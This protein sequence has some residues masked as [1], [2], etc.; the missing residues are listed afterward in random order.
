[1][2]TDIQ[3]LRG[4]AVLLV[5]FYHAEFSWFSKGYLGVDVF[6]VVSGY[7]I[8]GLIVRDLDN[9]TFSFKQFYFRRLK[10]LA[11]AAYATFA[12]TSVIA[13]YLLSS[14]ELEDYLK[15]LIGA[16]TFTGNIALW[17]QTGYFQGAA[18]FKPLLH[19]WSLAIEEQFYLVLP[20][21][22]YLLPAARRYKL[23]V[24]ACALS[25]VL[26]WLLVTMRPSE[27]FYML[28]TR[29]WELLLGGLLALTQVPKMDERIGNLISLI[30]LL[31][32]GYV[33]CFGIDYAHPRWD[34]LI[35][36]LATMTLIA[37]SPSW[38][39]SGLVV[40]GLSKVG[41][42]SYSLYL[43]HWPIFSFARNI[44]LG[45]TL[46]FAL[47]IAL[48][49]LSFVLA[50]LQYQWIEQKFRHWRFDNAKPLALSVGAATFALP[51]AVFLSLTVRE[52]NSDTDWRSVRQAN[53]GLAEVCENDQAFELK[54]QC[55]TRDPAQVL[56]WG[57]SFAMHLMDGIAAQQNLRGVVQATKSS[58]GPNLSLA[59]FEPE[60]LRYQDWSESCLSFN[61]SVVDFIGQYKS[62]DTVVL[63]ST[64]GYYFDRA[65]QDGE[66]IASDMEMAIDSFQQT[67]AA[68]RAQ[69]VEVVIIAPPPSV[70]VNIASCLERVNNGLP[71]QSSWLNSD[72][73]FD[74]QTYQNKKQPVRQLLT[75]LADA[76]DVHVIWPDETLCND[77]IC[78]SQ[79]LDVPLYRDASH[80]SKVG[81]IAYANAA[82]L[83]EQIL[84]F[85]K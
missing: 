83:G 31:A 85:S 17:M 76:S 23:L 51:L 37:A 82:K 69:H 55:L 39:K 57:D 6:F 44:Y 59:P 14:N 32:L 49:G 24:L 78:Q 58:C 29:A 26:C 80:L 20:V 18:E 79:L 75:A 46:P 36:C 5:L 77:G 63:A 45:E 65:Y 8:T 38:L 62:I 3:V 16:L 30:A 7:L 15:Q 41:D 34:A 74:Q 12:I 4:I 70:G 60:R 52:Q 1:M 42:W 67:I 56:V 54:A 53:Y 19:V 61:R 64:F 10:R 25:M 22:L 27:T 66:V 71:V 11:P 2:R 81:S 84:Y 73:S 9:G 48:V 28:P 50:Y 40:N 13:F 47:S 35:A 68:L 72:C 21:A 33:A 43:V